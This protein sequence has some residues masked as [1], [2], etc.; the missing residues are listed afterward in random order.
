M[1]ACIT[2]YTVFTLVKYILTSSSLYPSTS[3]NMKVELWRLDLAANR[4][5]SKYVAT[6]VHGDSI[7]MLDIGTGDLLVTCPSN[8]M[9]L[10]IFIEMRGNEC[11]SLTMA[12]IH[13]RP[14]DM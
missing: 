7:T 10:L 11:N 1:P 8:G 6:L 12:C 9:P 14:T 2:T 13:K 4:G 5:T 3:T